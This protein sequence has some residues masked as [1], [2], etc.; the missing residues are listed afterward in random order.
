MRAA[1]YHA[2]G[3]FRLSP[4]PATTT[5][6]WIQ[7]AP[8]AP[9]FVDETGAAFTPIGQND[10]IS[11]PE[12][13]GLFR[14][15]DMASV[16]G[17]LRWLKGHGVNTLR[18]MLEYAQVRHRY[19]EQP[20]G[21]FVPAMVQLWDDLFALCEKLELRIL[22]TPVDT[23][24][25]WRHWKHLPWNKA[26]GGPLGSMSEVL[27]CPATRQAIK[28]RFEFVVRRWG[29]SGVLFAWDLWN[30]IHPAQGGEEVECWDEFVHDISTHVRS[31]ELE[32]YGR[33]HPQTVSIFGPEIVL[34]PHH[35][36]AMRQ[37][38]FRHP[39]L[40]FASIHIYATG[41][42]DNPK[43]TVQP[44][45]V[46]GGIV[47]ECLREIDDN[48][49]FLDSEHGPIYNFINKKKTLP[50]PFDDE[51]FRHLSWAHLASGGAGGG[52]RWPNRHP[53]T[54]THGMRR[55][56]KA[57]ADFLPHI[58]WPSFRRR[59]L[60]GCVKARHFHAFACGD[61]TQA[62]IWLLRRDNLGSDKRLRRDAVPVTT[63]FTIPGLA[64][65]TYRV[66]GWD[67]EQGAMREDFSAIAS[68]G[69]LKVTTADIVTD[70]AYAI[71]RN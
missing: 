3:A 9:Y 25:M 18:L 62:L 49:P 63:S 39:D 13:A 36:P 45:L 54:L 59:N 19:F 27:T 70:R 6:P 26:N 34:Q 40:D 52:M 31:L 5:L 48:R 50:E 46:M 15:K 11:W 22:L 12:L 14:R 1:M 28:N 67:T 4:S 64:D 24:W 65:G 37:T 30:E 21:R 47:G 51:Y 8:D 57:M 23:F 68:G 20:A 69:T 16:E 71:T 10:A 29:G 55:A 66:R 44:A 42:I 7:V 53:H 2:S 35:A 41:S 33:S 61:E 56:Q 38:L 58:D 32:L 60:S 43:D 17:H